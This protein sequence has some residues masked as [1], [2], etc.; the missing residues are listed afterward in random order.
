MN[1]QKLEQILAKE[2]FRERTYSL[3]GEAD[4]ALCL[5]FESGKWYVFFSERGMRTGQT[6]FDSETAA[7]EYFLAKMRADPTTKR[8]WTSGFRTPRL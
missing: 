7:C 3:A 2:N 6:E 8:D 4:E 5:S 1:R